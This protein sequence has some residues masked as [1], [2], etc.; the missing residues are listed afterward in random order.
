MCFANFNAFKILFSSTFNMQQGFFKMTMITH[1]Q[2][3][4][5]HPFDDNPSLIMAQYIDFHNF[6]I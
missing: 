6:V 5:Q 3:A 4:M 1:A 2:I